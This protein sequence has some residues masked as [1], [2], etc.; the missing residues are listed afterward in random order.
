MTRTEI[1]V[2]REAL[3]GLHDRMDRL[4]R[5]IEMIAAKLDRAR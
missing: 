2:S 5:L 1:L 3:A 4:E